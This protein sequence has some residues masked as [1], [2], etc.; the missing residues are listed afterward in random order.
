MRKGST[1]EQDSNQHQFSEP[2][3]A[4]ILGASLPV[5]RQGAMCASRHIS[6]EQQRRWAGIGSPEGK[7]EFGQFPC[8]PCLPA[9]RRQA[10]LSL[11]VDV[12]GQHNLLV[13]PRTW[14]KFSLLNLTL[15]RILLS[16]RE[17]FVGNVRLPRPAL[18]GSQ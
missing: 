2:I 5:G 6:D 10:G 12:L 8:L 3:P 18:R 4:Q 1:G 7:R 17:G 16:R 9:G 11:L 13:V 15:V 14:L